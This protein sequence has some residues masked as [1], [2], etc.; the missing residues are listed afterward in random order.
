MS[1]VRRLRLG[2]RTLAVRIA[3]SFAPELADF[4]YE[5]AARLHVTKSKVVNDLVAAQ[6]DLRKQ[7]AA[8][9]IKNEGG[10]HLIHDLVERAKAE[11]SRSIDTQAAETTALRGQ[12]MTAC[13]MIDRAFYAYLLHTPTVPE[14][15]QAIAREEAQRRYQKW[16]NEVQAQAPPKR[17]EGHGRIHPTATTP[18]TPDRKAHAGARAGGDGR[19]GR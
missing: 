3:I 14:E 5:E 1:T 12:V 10:T 18:R 8:V 9:E 13:A 7:M 2:R 19:A 16:I 6:L 17:E 11:I 4:V 15:Q